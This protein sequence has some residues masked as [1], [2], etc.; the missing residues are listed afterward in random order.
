MEFATSSPTR[1]MNPEALAAKMLD[2]YWDGSLPIDPV[3]I[4]RSAGVDVYG[5]G[6][7]DD[8]GYEYSG[9]FRRIHDT[10]S[11][12]YNV[13][14]APVRQRFTVA[15]ELGHFALQHSDLP[16]DRGNF[17]SSKDS[18][19]VAANRFAAELLMPARTVKQLFASGNAD[20][21]DHLARMFGVSAA[22]LGYRLIN[23]RLV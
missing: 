13:T 16:R 21:P 9:Y 1:L 22:A 23:L 12:E 15:H 2:L 4:A 20:S 5:R 14:E 18:R 6:G 11:I 10:P 7:P 19:E 17:Q 3:K 8:P